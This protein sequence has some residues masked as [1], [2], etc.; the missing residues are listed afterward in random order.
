MLCGGEGGSI[1]RRGS[2]STALSVRPLLKAALDSEK[3]KSPTGYQPRFL[4]LVPSVAIMTIMI[5]S[6]QAPTKPPIKADYTNIADPSVSASAQS[7][8]A[9]PATEGSA[10]WLANIQAIQNLMGFV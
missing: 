8:A 3:L 10:A 1:R 2:P 9:G 5:T 6:Y 4:L 7:P